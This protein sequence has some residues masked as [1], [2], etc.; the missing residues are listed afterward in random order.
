[1]REHKYRGKRV[2]DGKWIYGSLIVIEHLSYI[3]S[4]SRKERVGHE[5]SF[6]GLSFFQV[7]PE[8]VGQ[9]TGLKDKNGV[10]IYEGDILTNGD[11]N[12]KYVV[13]WIDSGLRA[14]QI[15]NKSSIGLSYWQI[16]LEVIGNIHD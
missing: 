1:M 8:S 7:L 4:H 14:R 11:I 2:S 5:G 9:F 12:I 16:Q 3:A 10:D 13:E 6:M 15:S